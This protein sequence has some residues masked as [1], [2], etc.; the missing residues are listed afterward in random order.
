MNVRRFILTVSDTDVIVMLMDETESSERKARWT[1]EQLLERLA[2]QPAN[3]HAGD[4][5]PAATVVTPR[6]LRFYRVQGLLS[7][8]HRGKKRKCVYDPR[9]LQELLTIR[10]LQRVGWD[11]ERIRVA[12]LLTRDRPELLD[13]L[14]GPCDEAMSEDRLRD[15]EQLISTESSR[16][17]ET[18]DRDAGPERRETQTAGPASRAQG[19]SSIRLACGVY[20]V[21]DRACYRPP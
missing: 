14:A 8:P 5:A 3:N 11:L 15:L 6:T 19:V 20:L 21:L 10:R 17:S 7:P 4:A 12:L 13:A 1:E 16:V 2:S 9:H 18:D